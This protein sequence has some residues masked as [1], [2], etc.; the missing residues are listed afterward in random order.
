MKIPVNRGKWEV[1][2]E[3]RRLVKEDE[4]G[5]RGGGFGWLDLLVGNFAEFALNFM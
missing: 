5:G 2:E 3:C 4:E 1:E